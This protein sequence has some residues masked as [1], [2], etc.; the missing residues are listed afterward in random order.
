MQKLSPIK[1]HFRPPMAPTLQRGVLIPRIVLCVV[2]KAKRNVPKK[3]THAM[4]FES[5]LHK[6]KS[7]ASRKPQ[8]QTRGTSGWELPPEIHSAVEALHVLVLFS[9]KEC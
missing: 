1:F 2:F 8:R 6:S 9:R 4:Q 5:A 7:F 3:L